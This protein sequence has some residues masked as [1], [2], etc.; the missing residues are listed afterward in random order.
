MSS[1]THRKILRSFLFWVIAVVFTLTI[2]YVQSATGPTYPISGKVNLGSETIGYNLKR[3]HELTDGKP[4]QWDMPIEIEIGNLSVEGIVLWKRYK[5]DEPLRNISMRHEGGF[6]RAGLPYQP[7]AG[8]LEYR[9]VLRRD[10]DEIIIPEEEPVVTRFKGDIPLWALLPHIFF[11]FFG[12]LFAAR[13]ALSAVFSS[14]IE[15]IVWVTMS[16]FVI[17]GLFF[18]P[19][20]QKCAFGAYWTGWP[21]GDDW[22]DNKTLLMVLAWIPALWLTRKKQANR[23]RICAIVAMAVTFAVYMIPHSMHGSEIDYNTV[24]QDSLKVEPS[25]SAVSLDS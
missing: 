12:L 11:M 24:N 4:E 18:G 17:G 16:L 1:E 20:V 21:L 25:S 23:A 15:T 2:A 6:L 19:V 14:R 3:T 13:T 10:A 22:T 7:P 9:V 5:Y 8:K